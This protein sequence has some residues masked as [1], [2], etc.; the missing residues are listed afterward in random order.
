MP[1]GAPRQYTGP[2]DDRNNAGLT[3]LVTLHGPAHFNIV[4]II[5]GE[6]VGADQEDNYIGGVEVVV[7]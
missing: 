4:A 2:Q 5:G 3:G 1:N 7:Y 6:K